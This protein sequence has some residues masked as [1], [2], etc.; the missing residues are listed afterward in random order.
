MAYFRPYLIILFETQIWLLGMNYCCYGSFYNCIMHKFISIK[1]IF[2]GRLIVIGFILNEAKWKNPYLRY[3]PV[4]HYHL[5]IALWRLLSLELHNKTTLHSMPF[6]CKVQPGIVKVIK[7]IYP[8]LLNITKFV[9]HFFKFSL[10]LRNVFRT[11][12]ACCN[13]IL[14]GHLQ[15]I[16][17]VFVSVIWWFNFILNAF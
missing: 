14:P 7:K 13:I 15:I 9:D 4:Q 5:H 17:Y 10:L 8:E 2:S 12:H 11:R 16:I 6:H 3:Q 1:Y